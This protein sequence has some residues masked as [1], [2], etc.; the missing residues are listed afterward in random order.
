[1]TV[2][3]DPLR[4]GMVLSDIVTGMAGVAGSVRFETAGTSGL[5]VASLLSS[6]GPFLGTSSDDDGT[7]PSHGEWLCEGHAPSGVVAL[8][9]DFA[10]GMRDSISVLGSLCGVSD[11][12]SVGV[13]ADVVSMLEGFLSSGEASASDV[14]ALGAAVTVGLVSDS[15]LADALSGGAGVGVSCHECAVVCG[16]LLRCGADA[17]WARSFVDAVLRGGVSVVLVDDFL[18]VCE[19]G[20][21]SRDM[22]N[23]YAADVE[24]GAASWNDLC[25]VVRGRLEMRRLGR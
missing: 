8:S 6:S 24:A 15:S 9:G 11:L 2:P 17:T 4:D 1:M 14:V 12:F 19:A 20:L 10:D 22:L 13:E 5:V 7:V 18:S 21:L 25:V 23:G 3:A 16:R